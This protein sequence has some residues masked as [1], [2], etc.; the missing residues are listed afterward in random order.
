MDLSSIAM[1]G[2]GIAVSVMI[3][4]WARTAAAI[5][6]NGREVAELRGRI[7]AMEGTD[8]NILGE[9]GNA[10]R[11]IGGV[12]RVADQTAGEVRQMRSTLTV[13]QQSALGRRGGEVVDGD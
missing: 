3:P 12:G 9:L 2:I 1:W 6:R 8:A 11:R 10:H 5:S 4:V 7:A 13:L